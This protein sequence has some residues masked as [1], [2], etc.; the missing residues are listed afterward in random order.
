VGTECSQCL[1]RILLDWRARQTAD[2]GFIG[3]ESEVQNGKRL[4]PA[5][6]TVREIGRSLCC[7]IAHDNSVNIIVSNYS[8]HV[9]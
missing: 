5:E 2:L 7:R 9:N 3:C 4:R 8:C 1:Q 6:L